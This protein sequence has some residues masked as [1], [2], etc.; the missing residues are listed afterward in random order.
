MRFGFDEI[1]LEHDPGPRHPESPDRLYAIREGLKRKHDVSYES[2]EPAS[3]DTMA[4]VHDREYLEQVEAF[5]AEGGGAWDADTIASERT[6]EAIR[7]SVGLACWVT[8]TA[9]DG[10]NGRQTPFSLGRPPGH[11]A[12]SDNAMGFCFVNNVAVATQYALEEHGCDRVAI[13]DWDVHH[14]NGTESIFNDRSDVLTCSIHQLGLY[15]GTGEVDEIGVGDGHGTTMNVP[16]VAGADDIDY[17]AVFDRA[18][19][20]ALA[21]FDPDLLLV[22]AGFDAHRRD[23]ISRTRLSTEGFACLTDRVRTAASEVDAPIGFV[24]EGGYALDGIADSVSLVHET[25]DGREP[26]EPEG[27]PSDDVE[28]ILSRIATLHELD[29]NPPD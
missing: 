5:C 12:I 3:I 17:L 27:T 4:L 21:R 1:C 24:L 7:A 23:P 18:I 13:I 29:T 22:S 2:A 26:I 14:G 28:D 11:H 19:R 6:W 8:E 15:P 20:P 10:S 16:M 9:L 25:F